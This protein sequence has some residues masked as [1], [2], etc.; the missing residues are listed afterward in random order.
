[1]NDFPPLPYSEPLRLH[2]IGAGVQRRLTPSL[3]RS[4]SPRVRPLTMATRPCKRSVNRF[5]TSV[6]RSSGP[7]ASGVG[8]RGANTPSRSRNRAGFE[9]A[10]G[11]WG[12]RE[13]IAPDADGIRSGLVS[14][15]LLRLVRTR[16]D[17]DG[18]A[19]G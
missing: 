5:S 6:R 8:A 1:M 4:I 3:I 9:G 15:L 12:R 17:R 2:H 11:G 14:L 7:T 18:C 16:R 10:T 13:A 19:L